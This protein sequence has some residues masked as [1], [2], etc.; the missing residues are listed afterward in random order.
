MRHELTRWQ[1]GKL[2]IQHRTCDGRTGN[3][4]PGRV[5]NPARPESINLVQWTD[6][7]IITMLQGR[8]AR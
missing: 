8:Y 6:A 4:L 2:A 1:P 3:G 7:I 5:C